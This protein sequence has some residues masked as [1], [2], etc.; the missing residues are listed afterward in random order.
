MTDMQK[1]NDDIRNAEDDPQPEDKPRYADGTYVMAM[2]EFEMKNKYEIPNTDP[3]DYRQIGI[4]ATFKFVE[5][6]YQGKEYKKYFGLRH[7]DSK[8]CV[9]YGLAGVKKLY[10]ATLGEMATNFNETFGIRFVAT[11]KSEKNEGNTDYPW[12]TDIT[13]YEK[14]VAPLPAP[15]GT[16]SIG[17]GANSTPQA[18]GT[19]NGQQEIDS[20]PF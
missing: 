4:W 8:M 14:Y 13:R 7:P 9:Q 1:F 18:P 6:P 12:S 10:R 5:G 2:V 17:A 19:W 11:L 20:I 16:T 3:L 15:T